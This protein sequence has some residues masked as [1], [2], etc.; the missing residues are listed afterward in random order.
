M[1]M[2]LRKEGPPPYYLFTS[3]KGKELIHGVF[4]RLGG[5]SQGTFASLN[6]GHTVGDDPAH[7]EANHRAIYR[8][9]G[10]QAEEVV[11]AHQVHGDRVAVV[12]LKDGGRVFPQTDALIS[13]VPGRFLLLRFADC[14]PVLFYAPRQ[15][16][17]GIA[18]A[19]WRGTL[20]RI[21]V[22]TVRA[23]EEAYGCRP[24]EILAGIGPSIGPC[25]FEVGPE[26]VEEA[27]K[28]F[29]TY[30]GILLPGEGDRSY[31]DLWRINELQ[32]REIGVLAIERADI[33]T[34]CHRAEFFSHR[35]DGGH[36]GR[37]AALIGLQ[38]PKP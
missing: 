37:F 22:K 4:T 24:E 15:R 29:P 23:M 13:Q 25:C 18:H 12:S 35:G 28:A 14:V 1:E 21:A 32:L 3:F 10:I 38:S 31:L 11:S 27:R 17:V 9:L 6:V 20:Q 33:C 2:V 7:V 16:A 8:A 36:T 5:F 30:E 19:G 34:F 26:V